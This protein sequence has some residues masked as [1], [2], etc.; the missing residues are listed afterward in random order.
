MHVGDIGLIVTVV[1]CGADVQVVVLF[2]FV[3]I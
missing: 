1:V 2:V 3:M